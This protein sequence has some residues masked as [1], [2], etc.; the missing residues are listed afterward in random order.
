MEIEIFCVS[1]YAA[2]YGG[3]L[4]IMGVFDAVA[5]HALPHS[6]TP[7][8]ITLKLRFGE[9]EIREHSL[10]IRLTDPFKHTVASI[11]G[12]ITPAQIKDT[13][14]YS[15]TLFI[16]NIQGFRFTKLGRH[17]IELFIDG[18]WYSALPLT[19]FQRAQTQSP[20]AA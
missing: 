7:L 12:K 5:V 1:D 20:K 4:S 19:I 18:E 15:S 17:N 3:K 13:L 6:H 2:N 10:E 11:K 8:A 16:G 9:K 14:N